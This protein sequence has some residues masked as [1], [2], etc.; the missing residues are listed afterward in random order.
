MTKNKT[1]LVQKGI[2]TPGLLQELLPSR[3]SPTPPFFFRIWTLIPDNC[4]PGNRD[5]DS[6]FEKLFSH[7]QISVRAHLC[8]PVHS[9]P[10][11]VKLMQLV[12]LKP[13][14]P[15]AILTRDKSAFFVFWL[16]TKTNFKNLR[17]ITVPW[18]THVSRKY[19]KCPLSNTNAVHEKGI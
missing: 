18:V 12:F 16:I 9:Y 8:S 4:S 6:Y 1:K 3:T 11:G 19:F 7:F 15:E 14:V 17:S 13:K 10:V 5:T 2:E